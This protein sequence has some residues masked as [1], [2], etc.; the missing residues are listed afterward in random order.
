[1]Q[2]ALFS[3]AVPPIRDGVC[4]ALTHL[5]ESM[6]REGIGYRIV[7]GIDP[8]P[9]LAS[10]RVVHKVP[11][12]PFPGYGYY[13]IALPVSPRLDRALDRFRPEI[14]HAANPTLL[15]L[16]ALSYGRRR[17]LPVVTS[18]HTNYVSYFPYYG[19]GKL[20]G[21]GWRILRWFHSRCRAT[22][23]PSPSTLETLRSQGIPRLDLW[24]R[25]VRRDRFAPGYRS[26]E[27][28]RSIGAGDEPVLLYVGRLVREKD[29]ADLVEAAGILRGRGTR[30]KLV[31][32]GDGPFGPDLRARLP[33]AHFT[34]YLT[35]IDL[36]RWYAS[37]DLF[38]FPSTTETFGNVILEAFASGL[39]VVGVRASGSRDLIVPGQNGLLAR[40]RNPGD[41]A[42]KI[43][44][45]LSDP[46]AH[47]AMRAGALRTVDRYDW[48]TINRRLITDYHRVVRE[49]RSP[50]REAA[51]EL[52]A[53]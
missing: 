9:D 7:S 14:L 3:E 11:S 23:V 38:V 49:H 29:L 46:S 41:F 20:Q 36:A 52:A 16:Y 45:V 27:L 17:N 48:G 26:E 40:P 2:V 1:M 35:G 44:S 47:Q 21:L 24:Q 50:V 31:L 10:R 32:V 12:V 34:G 33:E 51:M 28:R 25:G 42:E 37:A 53:G 13:R 18:Y 8:A 4:H 5:T 30:F 39:P 43:R 19:L 15:G 6:D 22:Y